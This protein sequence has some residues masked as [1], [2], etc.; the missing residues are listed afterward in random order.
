M[1]EGYARS[2]PP[3]HARIID[4]IGVRAAAAL[5]VGCGAGLSTAPL[6]RLADR[7]VGVDPVPAMVRWAGR[8]VP[9]ASFTAAAAEALPFPDGVFDLITAAGSL[10]YAE[11]AAAFRELRRVIGSAG[12]LCVY[13][14]DQ[15][16]FQYQRPPDSAIPLNPE[17]L[18]RMDTGFR[19]ARS[20]AFELPVAMTREQYVAYLATETDASPLEQADTIELR[21]RG[22]L[23]WLTPASL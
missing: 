23:A 7:V 10:N 15:V 9:G 6:V 17:I 16:D 2:R 13:D 12:T 22:Y 5:D 21:F 14:F 3:L 8:I 4:R 20:E 11:P 1:A 19:V 18:A